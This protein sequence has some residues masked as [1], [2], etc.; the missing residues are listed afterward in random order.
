[1]QE[2]MVICFKDESIIRV[3]EIVKRHSENK[4]VLQLT[5]D[6]HEERRDD[7]FVVTLYKEATENILELWL[8]LSKS[9]ESV[10][11]VSIKGILYIVYFLA[12]K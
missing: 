11:F 2:N 12:G 7:E 6:F 1:M 10:A 3:D 9:D 5:R 8:T 4:A